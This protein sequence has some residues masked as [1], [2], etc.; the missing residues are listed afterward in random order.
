MLPAMLIVYEDDNR[1]GSRLASFNRVS[2]G[3]K[4]R[5]R[6]GLRIIAETRRPL[7]TLYPLKVKGRTG[8]SPGFIGLRGR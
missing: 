5:N 2:V 1:S 3:R 4:P 7:L 6:I 8:Q